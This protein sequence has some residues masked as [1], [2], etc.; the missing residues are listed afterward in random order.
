MYIFTDATYA[1]VTYG[2]YDFQ[3]TP[4][5]RNRNSAKFSELQSHFCNDVS[6]NNMDMYGFKMLL[7]AVLVHTLVYDVCLCL[8]QD[9]F[10][11][12][13]AFNSETVE[14]TTTPTEITQL[15]KIPKFGKQTDK[16]CFTR[17]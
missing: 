7:L 12:F 10:L 6:I 1:N 15:N 14:E 8:S 4:E 9:Y 3:W 13:E 17:G 5:L 16:V 2:L 11:Y